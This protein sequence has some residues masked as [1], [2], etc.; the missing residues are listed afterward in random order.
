MT[1]RCIYCGKYLTKA[2]MAM[3]CDGWE[4]QCVYSM[5]AK[6]LRRKDQVMKTFL[7]HKFEAE[8]LIAQGDG[9]RHGFRFNAGL[10]RPVPTEYGVINGKVYFDDFPHCGCGQRHRLLTFGLANRL[11]H[12]RPGRRRPLSA[13]IREKALDLYGHRCARCGSTEQLEIHHRRWVAQ[14]GT[15]RLS[16]LVVLCEHC[17]LRHSRDFDDLIWPDLQRVFLES[18]PSKREA[19]TGLQA[20]G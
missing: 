10:A 19:E 11:L 7:I 16:N 9:F 5:R 18:E 2:E 14:G 17:H 6:I 20:R 15:N 12:I 13:R 1:L 8:G 3:L 4:F